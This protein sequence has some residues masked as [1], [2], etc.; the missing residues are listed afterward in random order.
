M[1]PIDKSSPPRRPL[2][3]KCFVSRVV[4]VLA[5][6]AVNPLFMHST[7]RSAPPQDAPLVETAPKSSQPPKADPAGS[8]AIAADSPRRTETVRLIAKCSPAVVAI[9]NLVPDEKPG[10]FRIASGSGSIIHPSGFILTNYHVVR[11]FVRAEVILADGRILPYQV[12]SAFPPDDLALIKVQVPEPLQTLPLGRSHDLLLGEPTLVLG[13]PDGLVQ[14]ASTGVVSGL[15]RVVSTQDAFLPSMIQTTAAINGGNSGGPLINALGEQI[16]LI[17]SKNQNAD[18]IGFAIAVDR[19][20]E[21][22]PLMVAAEQR[23]DF[24]L[25][26]EIKMLTASATVQSVADGSPA[27]RADIRPGD[28]VTRV[29]GQ[30]ISCGTDFHLAMIGRKAGERLSMQLESDGKERQVELALD[31]LPAI[32]TVSDDGLVAGLDFSVFTGSWQKLPD[33]ETMTPTEKGTAAKPGLAAFGDGKDGFGLRFE[34]FVKLTADGL[35]A[36]F[37]KSDD[38]SQLRIGDRL[39]VDNDGQHPAREAAGLIRMKAGIYPFDL[40]FFE[41]Q[42]QE[43]LQVSIEGPGLTKQEIPETMFLRRPAAAPSP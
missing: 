35:Y 32:A 4:I 5:V 8:T 28:I 39:V 38:G 24:Y 11:T 14:S 40:R 16:G 9:R 31:N 13:N 30:S 43:F 18:N 2:T 12:I 1:E 29:S 33:F 3:S 23:S 25:G 41:G 10:T 37:T 6:M 7:A 26:L 21:Q 36:F 27:A 22:F 19:I 34:G 15:S 42:G 17:T 20:R